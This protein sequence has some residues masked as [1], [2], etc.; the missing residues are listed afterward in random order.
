MVITIQSFRLAR[1]RI[2]RAS[3]QLPGERLP[4]EYIQETRPI[5][6]LDE[7][8]NMEREK[9]RAALR[10]L[11]P[12]FA[13][14]YSATHRSSP[15]H[16]YSLTPFEAFQRGLVK[17]IQVDAITARDDF[18]RPFLALEAINR[19]RSITAK[20]RTYATDGARTREAEVSLKQG[21]DL[22]AKTGRDEHEG[23]IVQEIH[24]GQGW[25]EFAN[26]VKLHLDE[27]IGPSRPEIFRVQIERTVQHHM[28]RQQELADEGIK[29]LSLFFIDRVA[30]YVDE[31]GI[32]RRL[33]VAA[34]EKYK[35]RFPLFR[36][37]DVDDVHN[38]YFAKRSRRGKPDEYIDTS[39]RTV[40]ERAAE[41]ATFQLIMRDKERLLSFDEPTCF[42]FAHSA[43]KE[44]WDNPNVFQI[45]TL[46]QTVSTMKKRQEI[47]RGLR[48]PV[49]QK[50]ERV[51]DDD[52]NILT[53]VANESYQTY[54]ETLQS[55][56]VE[57]GHA[58]PPPKPTQVREATAYRNDD[59]YNDDRFR[60]LWTKLLQRTDYRIHIDTPTL[61]QDCIDYLNTVAQFPRPVIVIE[62]GE[63]VV[64]TFT[65]TLEAIRGNEVKIRVRAVDTRDNEW[66]Q[67]PYL[68]RNADLAKLFDEPRLR[69]FKIKT[70]HAAGNDTLVT[71][72][73]G[74]ELSMHGKIQ[75]ET[76][77]GQRPRRQQVTPEDHTYP[78]FNLIARAARE[79]SL[80][81]P[82]L[83]TIFKGLRDDKKRMLL[84]NPEGFAATFIAGVTE[85]LA[86][87][88]VDH[89]QFVLDE[90]PA[91]GDFE[92][93]FPE[94][95]RF[96]QREL[97]PAGGNGLYDQVQTDSEVERHFV[98]RQLIPDENV[99]GYFKFPTKFKVPFPKLI[100]NYN[101]DWGILRYDD[102]GAVVLELVRETKGTEEL[103]RL[104]FPHEKRKVR[105]AQK[106][107]KEV[108]I[109]YRVITDVTPGWW[110]SS[111]SLPTQDE[112][113]L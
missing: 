13:L 23:Y 47:G 74:E 28:Q 76:Q 59:L 60:D 39:G 34:F 92:R 96:V 30:N 109:D 9:A 95:K 40:R 26:G 58:T 88:V 33:F 73:N 52:V 84:R 10:T 43:L 93:Y 68:S 102:A 12:L 36:D 31:G 50:G 83:N 99:I 70:I 48:I 11:H 49:N 54:A 2:Y 35:S 15:N 69:G 82:T 87:H 72:A 105:A 79:T 20:V 53:V 113:D 85:V 106:H 1:N 32:I 27:T 98:A 5:L 103:E 100:G 24:A 61:I 67:A 8:Q 112:L 62:T 6:I 94:E 41:R 91:A 3:E 75:F 18:N 17:R 57:D 81:R 55:E 111:E 44:G 71:F 16:I 4:Y 101:P 77:E 90:T 22:H 63:Y 64:T 80:T 65:I 56:Y 46:N 38:G 107:F 45:C 51:F 108:G 37:V 86:N 29:V 7:P 104:Q 21:D 78:V 19:G 25:V 66:V 89:I 97:V 14:R 110:H 42:I